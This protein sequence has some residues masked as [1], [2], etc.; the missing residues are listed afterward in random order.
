[1]NP[2]GENGRVLDLGP[3]TSS[4]TVARR[5]PGAR[6]VK[7]FNTIYF[8]HLAEDGRPGSKLETRRAIPV[9]GDDAAAKA[10]VAG[11]I[12]D[13]GFA[14]LDLGGLRDGGRR[15]EPGAPLYNN[16]ASLEGARAML[17]RG[18]A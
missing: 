12:E 16:R 5:L 4:E 1:M 2:Y 6:L 14:A 9:S 7:A 8:V 11:L 18:E 13:I 15:Q 17:E 3:D 10:V